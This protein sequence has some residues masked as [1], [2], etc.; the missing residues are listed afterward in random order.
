M[1][2]PTQPCRVLCVLLCLLAWAPPAFSQPPAAD[3]NVVFSIE[4]WAHWAP[5][6]GADSPALTLY[7]NRDLIFYNRQADRYD[8]VQLTEGEYT[9]L[10]EEIIP[11]DLAMLEDGYY[12]FYATCQNVYH[13]YFGGQLQR[14]VWV[15][16]H[17][18]VYVAD[19]EWAFDIP[20]SL[21]RCF[22]TVE[23]YQNNRAVRWLPETI[24][25]IVWDMWPT[26]KEYLAWPADWPDLD[27]PDTI[28]RSEVYSV[29]LPNALYDEF[30]ALLD[31]S[32][33]I[34]MM[35]GKPMV[36]SYRISIPGEEVF[37]WQPEEEEEQTPL[38]VAARR[39]DL[40]TVTSLVEAGAD[41]NVTN[42]EGYTLLHMAVGNGRWEV[43]E[44]L[45]ANDA[46]VNA[47]TQTGTTVLHMAVGWGEDSP[48]ALL[49]SHGA[50]V[51]VQAQNGKTALHLTGE[52]GDYRAAQ[53]LVTH[54]ADIEAKT[55]YG[56]TPLLCALD[57]RE[58]NVATVLLANGADV[59]ARNDAN[60][61]GLHYTT[62]DLL[63]EA[64]GQLIA[65]G[66]DVN[67]RNDVNDT[68]LYA[69]A[70]DGAVA[71]VEL[72][73]A[74]GADLKAAKTDGRTA[75]H[76][77]AFQG[78]AEIVQL[79]IDHDADIYAETEEG[80]TPLDC[81]VSANRYDVV[82]LIRATRLEEN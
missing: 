57:F 82:T 30:M 62:E 60:D 55:A 34:V 8:T 29:F 80:Q 33:G 35:N 59:L 38:Y 19:D 50:D 81:A 44:F 1:H 10:L 31:E 7:D 14:M 65:G 71:I 77:A 51:G 49:L 5:V 17:P 15:Y 40:E 21:R 56:N 2:V 70:R 67:T 53:L 36:I 63:A 13:F 79:L 3:P 26:E 68:P 42:N 4:E 54:G 43:M 11:K 72:L 28:R 37:S 78:H 6:F 48:I 47:Q 69:A 75:L 12:R 9:R 23:R 25:V 24:E 45:L 76:A 52:W 66:L 32:K 73:L 27:S 64:A 20:Q 18:T 16:G 22:N 39:G 74:H 46:D 61:T 41:V 58:P